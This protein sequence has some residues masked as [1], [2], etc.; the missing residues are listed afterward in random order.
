MPPPPSAVPDDRPRVG[1]PPRISR[2][3]IAEAAHELGLD[4]LTLK[5]V[6]DH[7]GVSIAALYHHVSGKDDLMRLAAEYSATK[8]PLPKDTGQHWALWLLEWARYN[9]DAFLAQP[10]LLAQYLEGAISAESIAGNVDVI[11]GLLVR[12]GFTITEANAAYNL[13]TS[14]AIG[15]AV[16]VIREREAQKVGRGALAEHQRVLD[17]SGAN[18]LPYL[19]ALL[20]DL[21]TAGYPSFGERITTVLIGIAIRRGEDWRDVLDVLA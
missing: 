14:C 5:A 20:T 3:M 6:A 1:R 19:R 2:A 16:G 8:V 11:L 12:Q 15:T 21:P 17:A 18:D 4:G 9:R 10:G 7:L 13:V